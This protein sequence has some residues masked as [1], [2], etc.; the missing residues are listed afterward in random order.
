MV[1]PLK[2]TAC[3]PSSSKANISTFVFF[4]FIPPEGSAGAPAPSDEPD[5]ST[6]WTRHKTENTLLLLDK[7]VRL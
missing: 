6:Y 1:Y 3:C 4:F 2:M 7:T 5:G